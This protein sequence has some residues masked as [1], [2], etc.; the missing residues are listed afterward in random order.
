MVGG[1]GDQLSQA[2]GFGF[3]GGM[4]TRYSRAPELFWPQ[5]VTTTTSAP[6]ASTLHRTPNAWDTTDSEFDRKQPDSLPPKREYCRSTR[7]A[8]QETRMQSR[9]TIC[10][11]HSLAFGPVSQSVEICV[12]SV[13]KKAST[14]RS[15]TG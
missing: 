10:E 4:M 7:F 2:H 14:P 11:P 15:P 5:V 3:A 8:I 13:V 9:I 12:S 1:R 6:G